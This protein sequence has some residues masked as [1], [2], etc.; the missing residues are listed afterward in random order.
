MGFARWL[1][2]RGGAVV[3][4]IN[5]KTNDYHIVAKVFLDD[6]GIDKTCPW[7]IGASIPKKISARKRATTATRPHNSKN[8][9]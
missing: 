4:V 5:E 2:M 3:C 7:T 1:R 6:R 8:G 9:G